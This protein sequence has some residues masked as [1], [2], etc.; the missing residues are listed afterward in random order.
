[1]KLEQ[2]DYE[3]QHRPGIDHGN[4]DGL[5]RSISIGR[6]CGK[7]T[8]ESCTN[9][10]KKMSLPQLAIANKKRDEIFCFWSIEL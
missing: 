3:I 8:C 10:K 4:A 2:Y 5:S 1:M 9:Q 6:H 7:P